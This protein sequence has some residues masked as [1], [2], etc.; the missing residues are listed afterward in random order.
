MNLEI[1]EKV[2]LVT[3]SSKGIGKE[4]ASVLNNEKCVVILNSRNK[5]LEKNYTNKKNGNSGTF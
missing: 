1:E 4:I 2:V 3:G 5:E